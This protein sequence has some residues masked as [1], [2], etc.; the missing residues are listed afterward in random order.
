MLARLKEQELV[1]DIAFAQFWK[2]NRESFNPRSQ[3]LTRL[4][5]K[6]KGVAED[7]INQA[8]DA[9]DDDDCAY[10]A[11][12]NKARS[13]PTSDYQSFRRRLGE[14][15]KRRGFSYGVINNTVKRLWTKQGG[16]SE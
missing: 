14:Y 5:L 16:Q 8:V 12:L 13:L 10:R 4:E 7:I 3:W 2:Q 1:D 11:A 6:R 15:L 9:V